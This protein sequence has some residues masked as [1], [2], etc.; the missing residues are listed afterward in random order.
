[1][2]ERPKVNIANANSA[3][4][5]E[6]PIHRANIVPM[7]WLKP[8][9]FSANPITP[10]LNTNQNALEAKP[11]KI[12]EVG[13]EVRTEDRKKKSSETSNPGITEVAQNRI[14]ENTMLMI[15]ASSDDIRSLRPKNWIAVNPSTS[16]PAVRKFLCVNVAPLLIFKVI[17]LASD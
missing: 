14:Q 9:S 7:R 10:P 2:S 11:E 6:S 16:T 1:M 4:A 3:L 15:L 17:C 5:Y 12:S 13:T 8:L